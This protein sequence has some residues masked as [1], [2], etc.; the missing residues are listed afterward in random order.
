M[1]GEFDAFALH[2]VLFCGLFKV[3]HIRLTL[4]TLKLLPWNYIMCL[5]CVSFLCRL[6]LR[7][8]HNKKQTEASSGRPSPS[9]SNFFHQVPPCKTFDFP[10]TTKIK[11]NLGMNNVS[12][13]SK[14]EN[15]ET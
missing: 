5:V 12:K 8:V 2:N 15:Y 13:K 10:S 4:I 1:N 3:C 9:S 6:K 14:P 7:L 11:I